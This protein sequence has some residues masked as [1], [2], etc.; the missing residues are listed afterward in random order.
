MA[1][2]AASSLA[3]A[4]LELLTHIGNLPYP[5]RYVAIE[6]KF[7]PTLHIQSL[8]KS[9]LP[10][11]WRDVSNID[12]TQ[13]IGD[14]WITCDESCILSVPSAI[15]PQERN[16]LINPSHSDFS[17]IAVVSK[18]YIDIDERLF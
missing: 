3:L 17:K 15:I 18:E 4:S 2:Y 5:G 13:K 1:V 10:S 11:N 8:R 14:A 7:P 9:E 6:A 12:E 16:Y